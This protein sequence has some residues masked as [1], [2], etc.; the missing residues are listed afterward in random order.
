MTQVKVK[1]DLEPAAC[2]VWVGVSPFLRAHAIISARTALAGKGP[3]SAH[4]TAPVPGLGGGPGTFPLTAQN[5]EKIFLTVQHEIPELPAVNPQESK[6]D[7]MG[8]CGA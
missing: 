2:A 3:F 8:T 4:S 1:Y 7:G 6:H 5:P